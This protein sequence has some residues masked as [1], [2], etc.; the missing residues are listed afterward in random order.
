MA[1]CQTLVPISVGKV[2]TNDIPPIVA[3][4]HLGK[5][6]LDHDGILEGRKQCKKRIQTLK[7]RNFSKF[8]FSEQLRNGFTGWKMDDLIDREQRRQ[9]LVHIR[10]CFKDILDDLFKREF[11][12]GDHKIKSGIKIQQLASKNSLRSEPILEYMPLLHETV[13]FA[14]HHGKDY[15]YKGYNFI[16]ELDLHLY[17]SMDILAYCLQLLINIVDRYEEKW[18]VTPTRPQVTR[19]L[20]IVVFSGV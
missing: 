7:A 15:K 1:T 2:C 17:S 8:G 16:N 5:I 11:P 18:L 13:K 9:A 4:M 20:H 6:Q 12:S 19:G 10:N 14:D 3:L